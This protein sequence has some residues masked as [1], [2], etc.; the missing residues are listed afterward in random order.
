MNKIIDL[1]LKILK[2]KYLYNFFY[3]INLLFIIFFLIYGYKFF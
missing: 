1:I 2:K 3:L